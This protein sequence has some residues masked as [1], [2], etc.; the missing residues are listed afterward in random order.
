MESEKIK[1]NINENKI[2]NPGEYKINENQKFL[3]LNDNNNK[4]H[5]N[6]IDPENYA[7]KITKSEVQ[8]L[9]SNKKFL[10]LNTNTRF[11]LSPRRDQMQSKEIQNLYPYD[12]K[13]SKNLIAPKIHIINEQEKLLI[14]KIDKKITENIKNRKDIEVLFKDPEINQY[15]LPDNFNEN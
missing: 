3:K 5:I 15:L 4:N 8:D 9:F 12:K 11:E 7:I 14:E 2:S 13:K 1:K 6:I 10:A